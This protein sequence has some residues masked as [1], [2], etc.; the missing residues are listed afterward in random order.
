MVVAT[1]A[2]D[3]SRVVVTFEKVNTK[4]MVVGCIGGRS[5]EVV[6]TTL[7][8]RFTAGDLPG[9]RDTTTATITKAATTALTVNDLL[10]TTLGI[11]SA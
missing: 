7:G 6:T 9:T 5:V 4:V 8:I 3:V 11:I 2:V 10:K 1:Y